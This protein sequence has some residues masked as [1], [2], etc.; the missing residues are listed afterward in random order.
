MKSKELVIER[1]KLYNAIVNG[2]KV[3]V[4]KHFSG[5]FVDWADCKTMYGIETIKI[6]NEYND[7]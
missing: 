6:L 2:K 5:E 7:E 1:K 4:Y 3:I